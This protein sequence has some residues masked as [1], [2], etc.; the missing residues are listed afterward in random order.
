MEQ[1]ASLRTAEGFV[2]GYH[3][4][5]IGLKRFSISTTMRRQCYALQTE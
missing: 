3:H 5:A 1:S 4:L 2:V